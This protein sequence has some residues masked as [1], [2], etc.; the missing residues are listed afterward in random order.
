MD[1]STR[2]E[3]LL[4][5]PVV[6]DAVKEQVRETAL[7]A[8]FV[9]CGFASAEPLDC[10]P[11]LA[12]WLEAGRHGS[13]DYLARDLV[14]RTS[15][16]AY[17]SGASTVVVAAWPYDPPPQPRGDWRRDLTGRIAAYA[18]GR[19]YHHRL[20]RSLEELAR[21]VSELAGGET[22]VHVDAGPLVEKDLARRAGL[23]WFGRNTNLLLKGRGSYLLLGCLLTQAR[24]E[25]DPAFD[26]DHC[27]TCTACLPACPT[28]ALDGGPTIDA[29]ACISYL[30]IERRGPIAPDLRPLM[31]NWVFGCDDCQTA[32]PWNDGEVP[33]TP[34][35]TPSLPEL[36]ALTDE[37]FRARYRDS[38][39]SRAKRRGLARNAA[40]A[41]GNSGSAAA[42]VPL[43][44]A[45]S[46]HDEALVRAH[47]AWALGNLGT[48]AAWLELERGARAERVPPVRRE[49]EWALA[50]RRRL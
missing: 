35:L 3:G 30:T 48:A 14:A 41:L 10:G 12:E 16:T 4:A 50:R 15:P 6:S 33:P 11:L 43:G 40:I 25:P 49:V 34:E 18:L 13:M 23:G 42:V 1:D 21:C 17:L 19:D 45:L 24:F 9:A 44:A 39:V 31:G 22:R 8:G 26:D 5:P 36:L 7:A 29:R 47:A 32:C 37:E 2:S 28:G 38:A 27:G 20:G 46:G